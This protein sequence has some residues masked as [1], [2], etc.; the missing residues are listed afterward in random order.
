[1]RRGASA[2]SSLA[3]VLLATKFNAFTQL[4]EDGWPVIITFMA[5]ILAFLLIVYWPRVA[6]WIER[7]WFRRL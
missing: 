6:A 1:V 5:I 7:R 3:Q 2:L 4:L